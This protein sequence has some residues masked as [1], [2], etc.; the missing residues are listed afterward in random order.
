[1]AGAAKSCSCRCKT[2]DRSA[3]E[4]PPGTTRARG[5]SRCRGAVRHRPNA[6]RGSKRSLVGRASLFRG[7]PAATPLATA[8]TE[9][10]RGATGSGA[11]SKRGYKTSQQG[12]RSCTTSPPTP[13]SPSPAWPWSTRS[14]GSPTTLAMYRPH[15]V[16][17]CRP[18]SARSA[19]V[20]DAWLHEPKLGGYRLQIIKTGRV[21][22]L[23]SRNGYDWTKRL[24]DLAGALGGI[25][26]RCATIDAQVVFPN[27]GSAP[28]YAGLQEAVA[29]GR[30]HGLGVFAFDALH[31]D[32][33]GLQPLP[34]IE[35]RRHLEQLLASSTVPCLH[36]VEA[37]DDSVK[38]LG[39]ASHR[40]RSSVKLVNRSAT[41]L[42]ALARGC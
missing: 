9:C 26:W 24:A 31:R 28:D 6:R 10:N 40:R 29:D 30:P 35:R 13:F 3:P 11:G 33:R 18:I 42:K 16:R 34:L 7:R 1:M 8:T 21:V 2:F 38:L 32:G 17:P 15:F 5:Q 12:S 41:W 37:F 14:A 19:P 20:G 39:A 23:Y 22:R 25:S 4:P 36:L 27:A